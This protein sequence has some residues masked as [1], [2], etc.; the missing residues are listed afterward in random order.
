MTSSNTPSVPAGH[1]VS[2][3][4]GRRRS[5][6]LTV[7]ELEVVRL[8]AEGEKVALISRR[9]HLSEHT[10]LNHIRNARESLGVANRLELVTRV[11][12]LGLLS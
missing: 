11:R 2:S 9:L 6:P 10:V 8:L 5:G 12:R 4:A 1:S 3:G 7:R